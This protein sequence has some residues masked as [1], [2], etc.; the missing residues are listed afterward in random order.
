MFGIGRHEQGVWLKFVFSIN[1]RVIKTKMRKTFVCTSIAVM[2]VVANAE[3]IDNTWWEANP[4][5]TCYMD[6]DCS[7]KDF[8]HFH[9]DG[10]LG[11]PT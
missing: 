9:P 11:P 5:L 4:D 1:F 2:L 10:S 8:E 7:I 3:D 6:D